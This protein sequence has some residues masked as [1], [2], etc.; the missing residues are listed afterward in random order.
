MK[1]I[2]YFYGKEKKIF[3][4]I[5]HSYWYDHTDYRICDLSLISTVLSILSFDNTFSISCFF[6]CKPPP[7]LKFSSILT[8][9]LGHIFFLI[10]FIHQVAYYSELI[11]STCVNFTN[12]V[13]LTFSASDF[14]HTIL[15][16]DKSV[17][18]WLDKF[19]IFH[20]LVWNV[21]DSDTNKHSA[22]FSPRSKH[23]LH[24]E[25]TVPYSQ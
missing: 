20:F 1:Q 14:V 10:P 5:I 24:N 18:I 21:L 3:F 8:K 22:T 15:S 17:L 13:Y 2:F 9:K 7:S 4:G 25:R 12:L 19:S 16:F 23:S 6:P 11:I